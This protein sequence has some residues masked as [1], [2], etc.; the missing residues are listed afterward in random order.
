LHN[1]QTGI[2]HTWYL[3]LKNRVDVYRHACHTSW[4]EEENINP[5]F[6]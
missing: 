5:V 4:H 1:P 2:K 3:I 6:L